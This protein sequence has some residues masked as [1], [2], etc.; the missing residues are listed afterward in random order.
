MPLVAARAV[1]AALI[2]LAVVACGAS[3]RSPGPPA[4][5]SRTIL[6][7]GATGSQG[8]ATARAL[9]ALGYRVRGLTRDPASDRARQMAALGV[10]LV[11]GDLNDPS[12]LRAAVEGAY[13]VFS[14]QNF[15]EH[16]REGEIRQGKNLA[17][18]ARAAGVQHFV[19]A[20]VG[21]ADRAA[22]V[23]HFESKWEIEKYVRGL[24]MPA[25]ILR[26]VSF[27]ENWEGDKETI[28]G[29]KLHSPLD[30]QTRF[31][32]I[33]VQDIGRLA[34][35]AFEHPESWVGKTV[36]IAGDD[37]VMADVVA[38]FERATGR[39]LQYEQVPW[40]V[41][42]QRAG[43]EITAMYRWFQADG[44]RA[45]VAGLRARF[46]FLLSFDEFLRREW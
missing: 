26:P 18:A 14:V 39:E 41:F 20:S 40:E 34:A 37:R 30:P 42:E 36:E 43:P 28:A 17:D 5:A 46:P 1:R 19:Y 33:A 27:M 24:G 31:Q 29:G 13:G 38:A 21:G 8:G 11:K 16:G 3:S 44:Y 12:T 32:Q 45:D 10:Q 6:V 15:W 23:A 2:A 35:E 25:T 9:L 22:G 4:R 7:T